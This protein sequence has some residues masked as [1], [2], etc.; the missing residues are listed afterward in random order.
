MSEFCSASGTPMPTHSFSKALL[1]M[2]GDKEA[3]M[4]D[5]GFVRVKDTH[6]KGKR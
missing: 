5:S 6:L 3:K 2:G 4:T 1:R